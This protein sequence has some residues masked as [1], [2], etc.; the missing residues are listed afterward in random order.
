MGSRW[1]TEDAISCYKTSKIYLLQLKSQDTM[2]LQTWKGHQA[3]NWEMMF[4]FFNVYN[5]L[6]LYSLADAAHP[7][8]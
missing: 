3:V 5:H 6:Y 7:V 2:L 4:H 8:V 1:Q